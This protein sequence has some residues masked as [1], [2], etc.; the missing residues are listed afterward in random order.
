MCGAVFQSLYRLEPTARVAPDDCVRR[1]SDNAPHHELPSAAAAQ[2]EQQLWAK[3]QTGGWRVP[4]AAALSSASAA[5][6]TVG[7]ASSA[8]QQQQPQQPRVYDCDLDVRWRLSVEDFVA[9]YLS[10][11]KPV[12]IKGVLSG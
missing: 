4:V 11:Q 3:V 10:I 5:A 7:S 2:Q 1:L 9:D 8:S 12:L 6:G